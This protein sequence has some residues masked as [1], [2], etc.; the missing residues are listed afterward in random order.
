MRA[1][2][3]LLALTSGGCS[4]RILHPAP[5]RVAWPDP[6]LP[7]SSEERCTATVLPVVADA[8]A[9][10]IFGT[11]G[12][13]EKDSGAPKV[14]FVV[15]SLAIPYL[16]SALYGAVTVSRCRTYKARFFDP[17]TGSHI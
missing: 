1:L 4:F 8:V 13:M 17:A 16:I 3:A 2:A 15:G 7:S 10:T 11:V 14:A 6:V 12:Y 9:G 5:P